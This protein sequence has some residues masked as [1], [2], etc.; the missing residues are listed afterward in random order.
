[1]GRDKL[2]AG[3]D[4]AWCRSLAL[5]PLSLPWTGADKG[6]VLPFQEQNSKKNMRQQQPETQ[7]HPGC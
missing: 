2:L 6:Q 5:L 7:A 3:G 4:D 1:M